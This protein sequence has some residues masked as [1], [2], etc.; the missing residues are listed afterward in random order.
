ME[1]EKVNH[2]DRYDQ[3]ILDHVSIH[4]RASV[5]EIARHVG[6]SKTPCQNR[7]KRLQAE[8]FI[9]GFRAVLNPARLNR[10]HVA[11]VE[12]KLH[13]TRE[14]ALQAFGAAVQAM[15][16]V[17]QCHMIAGG[18]DFLLK[19]RTKDIQEYRQVLGESLSALPHVANTSTHVS[20]QSV[21][22]SAF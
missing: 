13:D 19:V 9:L 17:E 3:A 8:G 5:V 2:L 20:M 21:K 6:L 14:P 15:P 11:F 16:Q 12:V 18:F 22:D 10:E 1:N 7:L 4:G